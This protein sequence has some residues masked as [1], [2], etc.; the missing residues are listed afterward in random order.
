MNEKI[1]I[2][3]DE[4]NFEIPYPQMDVHISKKGEE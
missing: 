2:K 4:N 3:F 1:K